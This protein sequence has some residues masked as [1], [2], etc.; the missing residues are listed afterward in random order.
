MPRGGSRKG[1]GRKS[2]W[3]NKET[4]VIRVPKVFAEQLL[5]IAQRLDRGESI[6]FVTKSKVKRIDKV[7]KSKKIKESVTK[8]KTS[9]LKVTDESGWLTTREVWDAL[10]QPKAWNTFRNLKEEALAN[11]GLEVDLSRKVKGKTDSRWL[12]FVESANC[13]EGITN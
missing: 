9:Q 1:A 6:E 4:T 8:S 3:N 13:M 11:Y 12:R 2:A 7:T 10:G 5:G